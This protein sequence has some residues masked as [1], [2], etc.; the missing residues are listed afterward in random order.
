MTTAAHCAPGS[1]M[2]RNEWHWCNGQAY[3]SSKLGVRVQVPYA[4]PICS[5]IPVLVEES[6]R[7]S[8]QCR[9]DS[10]LEHHS[11]LLQ[12]PSPGRGI[13]TRIRSVQVR[14]LSG[15]PFYPVRPK[16]RTRSYGLRDVGWIPARDTMI[17]SSNWQDPGL[18][19]RQM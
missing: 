16:Q 18:L 17:F 10:C 19:I 1:A 14:L 8:V 5:S 11:N 12:Y 13:G 2:S 9:F 4:A 15:A 6:E 7:E 3:Q